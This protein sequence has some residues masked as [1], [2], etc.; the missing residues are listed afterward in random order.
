MNTMTTSSRTKMAV[1]TIVAAL[2]AL[3][4]ACGR[5]EASAPAVQPSPPAKDSME[6]MP[7]PE[8]TAAQPASSEVNTA[9]G[10]I[11]KVVPQTRT[12]TIAHGWG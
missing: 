5:Q 7:M 8:S 9:E 3:L 6:G 2:G 1:L 11:R 4:A 10:T 12:V